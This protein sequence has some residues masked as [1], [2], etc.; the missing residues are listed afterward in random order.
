MDFN[1][2]NQQDT[3]GERDEKKLFTKI[4]KYDKDAFIQAYDLYVNQIYRFI[5]F[6]VNDPEEAQDLTSAV[7]LK[8]WNYILENSISNFKTLKALIY[9]IAR[10]SVIDH[11]RKN[12]GISNISLNGENEIDLPDEK[13]D[14]LKTTEL[15]SDFNNLEKKLWELKDEYREIIILK[16]IDELSISEIAKILEKSKGN[17]RIT[18][19]RALKALRELT[20]EK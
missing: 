7:F 11:Y 20:E 8:T 6:K 17:T 2:N 10:T 15:N 3:A 4:K 19:Y 14:V 16:Y 12:S 1:A 5:Y 9:K 13:Q 18:L